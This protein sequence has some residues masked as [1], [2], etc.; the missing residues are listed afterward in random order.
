M[1]YIVKNQHHAL[2]NCEFE[3]KH[4]KAETNKLMKFVASTE[5]AIEGAKKGVT[6][7]ALSKV[8]FNFDYGLGGFYRRM[9][10]LRQVVER[11]QVEKTIEA[12]SERAYFNL[13]PP[14]QV[15]FLN[16]LKE[17]EVAD[18]YLIEE[19]GDVRVLTLDDLS[20]MLEE[21]KE[22]YL[23]ELWFMSL[24]H[25]TIEEYDAI[26]KDVD[27]SAYMERYKHEL[28]SPEDEEIGGELLN[29]F[30]SFKNQ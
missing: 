3:V 29:V 24:I 17:L 4:H 19:N 10:S 23:G 2:S 8:Y 13:L 20:E 27:V 11:S 22:D 7:S 5:K 1:K 9:S 14:I 21:F 30:N 6:K 12:L 18:W 16:Y 15:R 28:Y 26:Y 25:F